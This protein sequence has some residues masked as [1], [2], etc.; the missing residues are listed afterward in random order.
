VTMTMMPH[1]PRWQASGGQGRSR[2]H[3]WLSALAQQLKG[4]TRRDSV[5]FDEEVVTD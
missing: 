3:A 2:L 1:E 4:P 5:N